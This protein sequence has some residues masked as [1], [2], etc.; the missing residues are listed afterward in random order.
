MKTPGASCALQTGFHQLPGQQAVGRGA[1]G[2]HHPHIQVGRVH[3]WRQ[4]LGSQRGARPPALQ[5]LLGQH[6]PLMQGPLSPLGGGTGQCIHAPLEP[7]VW[8]LAP[9][10]LG[11]SDLWMPRYSPTSRGSVSVRTRISVKPCAPK[12]CAW[13]K[14]SSSQ[15]LETP[16]TF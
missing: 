6:L 1:P 12:V 11:L 14:D 5:R 9:W 13:N 10:G 4:R 2:S 16:T 15:L 3:A 8:G 7:G